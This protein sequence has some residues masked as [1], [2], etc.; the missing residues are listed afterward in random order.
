VPTLS[1]YA[2]D[3]EGQVQE[4]RAC[5]RCGGCAPLP[6]DIDRCKTCRRSA[7]PI[8]VR[9]LGEHFTGADVLDMMSAGSVFAAAITDVVHHQIGDPGVWDCYGSPPDELARLRDALEGVQRAIR[10]A[11]AGLGAVERR[12]RRRASRQRSYGR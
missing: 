9:L 2:S 12:A 6:P 3:A 10:A 4:W 1:N 7:Q 11:R 5:A 8:K